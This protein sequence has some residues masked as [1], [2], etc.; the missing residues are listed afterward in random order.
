MKTRAAREI[1]EYQIYRHISNTGNKQT[2]NTKSKVSNDENKYKNRTIHMNI[3]KHNSYERKEIREKH[4]EANTQCETKQYIG[5]QDNT[6][7]CNPINPTCT[8]YMSKNSRTACRKQYERRMKTLL[9]F[10]ENTIY[11]CKLFSRYSRKIYQQV[12]VL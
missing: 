9:G 11:L 6:R 10:V 7:S 8:I 4:H 5:T 2:N 12:D 1:I 3:S